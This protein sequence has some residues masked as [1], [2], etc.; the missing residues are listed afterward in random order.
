MA[1]F[2]ISVVI[3]TAL[4]LSFYVPAFPWSAIAPGNVH[5]AGQAL[6]AAAILIIVSG[7]FRKNQARGVTEMKFLKAKRSSTGENA[8]GGGI[9]FGGLPLPPDSAT[10]HFMVVGSTGSGKTLTLR[11]AMGSVLPALLT[12]PDQRAVVFDAKQDAISVLWGILD[13]AMR[14]S[15]GVDRDFTVEIAKR[16]FILNP[17]DQRCY[18]WNIA[19]DVRSPEVALQFATILIPEES[20]PN[21]YFSDA[22][23]DLL[24]G[25][26]NVLVERSGEEWRFS[27]I[28]YAMRSGDR[29]R[30]V[31]RQT[32]EGEDL[33]DLH[34]EGGNT[35]RSVISTAR[36]KLAP[37][38]VVAALWRHAG[39]AGRRI[40]LHEFLRSNSILVLGTN[41]A[42]LAPIQAVNRVIFQRMTELILNQSE[43]EE[44][45]NWFFL[46]ELRKLGRLDG[47]DALMTNGR[48][49]GAAVFVGFQ[50]IDG[51]RA[52]YGREIAGEITSMC[53]S[54]G[55]LRVAGASTPQW[56]SEI[57]GEHEVVQKTRSQSDTF[58]GGGTTYGSYTTGESE[59]IREKRLYL[60]SFFRMVPR[61]EIGKPLY[62]YFCSA[63]LQSKPYY[64]EIPP[65]EVD[66]MLVEKASSDLDFEPWPD[67]TSKKL[68]LWTATDFERLNLPPMRITVPGVAEPAGAPG[69]QFID[70]FASHRVN[71]L[72]EQEA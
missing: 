23:R 56:A 2:L 19:A 8:P 32:P 43:N 34:L 60:P 36:S 62:G 13:D 71:P 11:M 31:L 28:L 72:P 41:Q 33:I 7:R 6:T 14:R 38:E 55:V 51:L 66:E 52:V 40:S 48:S 61:P 10:S 54:F 45:R 50:D 1:P 42:A 69:Q 15:S 68:P 59:H 64:A 29:L 53:A 46:D 47:L 70:P 9:Y 67:T 22:A 44:R 20:G 63:Y 49:K 30:H 37:Y 58:G 24:T 18:E 39:A 27:D 57:F 35:T 25:V 16:I 3:L 12:Q 4:A 65:G 5:L 17:F 26:I 21:R